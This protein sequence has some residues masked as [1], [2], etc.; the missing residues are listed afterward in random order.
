MDKIRPKSVTIISWII[1]ALGCI[2]LLNVV[3]MPAILSKPEYQKL[4]D[5]TGQSLRIAMLL[6]SVYAALF[7]VCG[8]A[9]LKGFNWGRLVYL[10]CYGV[11][12][13]LNIAFSRLS[14]LVL[15]SVVVFVTFLFFLTR[16]AANEFFSKSKESEE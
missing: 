2:T 4:A 14:L 8:V 16:P 5:V 13:V 6:S 1:I 3:R 7:L 11:M 9:M 10:W 12:V 15:P